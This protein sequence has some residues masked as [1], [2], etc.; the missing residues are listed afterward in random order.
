[1]IIWSLYADFKH[2]G[3]QNHREKSCYVASE[4]IALDH[5]QSKMILLMLSEKTVILVHFCILFRPFGFHSSKH[6]NILT[7]SVPDEGFCFSD[8]KPVVF[9]NLAQMIII[10]SWTVTWYRYNITE[11]YLPCV[12]TNHRFYDNKNSR[13]QLFTK[14]YE[15][16]C[17]HASLVNHS[18][19]LLCL[20]D[21][22]VSLISW[23]KRH[24]SGRQNFMYP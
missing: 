24:M 2:L 1:L 7:L 22:R 20:I 18:N 3:D 16:S 6:S 10:I 8:H 19:I 4:F 21:I 12:S 23:K 9:K 14:W 15:N 17:D 13:Y 11:N 5:Y